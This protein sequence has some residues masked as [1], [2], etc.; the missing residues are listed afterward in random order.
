[1]SPIPRSR[2]MSP[3]ARRKLFAS[4]A[5]ALALALVGCSSTPEVTASATP[6]ATE[7]DTPDAT[8]SATAPDKPDSLTINTFSGVFQENL[9]AY[10]V[11][12]FE[13][14][15]GITVNLVTSAPPLATLAAQGDNPEIDLFI[16]GDPQRMLAQMQGLLAA[17]DP[18]VVTNAA[19]LYPVARA[20]ESS[21]V[22]NYASQGL[23]YDTTKVTPSPTSWFDLF[24]L[25]L[26]NAVVVRAPDAQNTVS[27]LTLMA[28]E[29]NGDWPSSI[30]DYDEVLARVETDLRPNL[31]AAAESS[32]DLAGYLYSQ[33][34]ALAVYQDNQVLVANQN[35]GT[36]LAFAAPEEGV[37][38]IATMVSLTNTQNKYWAE[39]LM[40]YMLDP[41]VQAQWAI[42]GYYGPSNMLTEVPEDIASEITYG[43][44]DI[45]A[46][47]QLPWEDIVEL[48]AELIERFNAAIAN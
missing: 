3:R 22:M 30:E 36:S 14:E 23:V 10:V 40:N 46:L 44:E 35:E 9:E 19:D 25:D 11:E 29:L 18:D 37:L 4:S 17:Y 32:G 16:A 13:E 8:E 24:D 45:D 6:D 20:S 5:L 43:Q 1:M 39:V 28:Y 41:D 34:A 12:P 21:A 2:D 48:S 26:P 27:W 38:P 33:Q 15:H 42:N 7:S 47:V 31:L